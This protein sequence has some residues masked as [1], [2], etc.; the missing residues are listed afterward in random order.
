MV[1][2]HLPTNVGQDS[3]LR[4]GIR[5]TRGAWVVILDADLQ[6]PPEALADLWAM[7]AGQR[8]VFAHRHGRYSSRSR[9][10]TS[11]V[12]RRLIRW[13]AGLPPGAGLYAL[14]DRPTAE[15]IAATSGEPFSLMAV[16]AG[17]R[18]PMVSVP[19]QR[20]PRC[21]GSSAYTSGMRLAKGLRSLIQSFSVRFRSPITMNHSR[22]PGDTLPR[23]SQEPVLDV[24]RRYFRVRRPVRML[25]DRTPYIQRHFDEVAA[26]AGFRAG[27]RVC[28]WGAGLGRF[29]RL[30]AATGVQLD[31]IELSPTQVGDC[32]RALA[33]WPEARV[34][35]GDVATVMRT[36]GG[37]YNAIVGFFMLHHLTGVMGY[38][39][40]AAKHLE[41]GG[42]LVFVEPN[43]WN[44]LYPLQITFTPGMKWQAEKGI[45]ELWPHYLRE[46]CERAGFRSVSI[47]RYGA[48]PRAAYNA[49]DRVGL[50]TLPERLVPPTLKPFQLLLAVL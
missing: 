22:S 6:D 8:V 50:A 18:G 31:A 10:L 40:A 45:Y 36:Q 2:E 41:P 33:D 13:I 46:Q 48:L 42:R 9:R 21:G 25:V 29:S 1:V 28:E 17:T 23:I 19:V 16:F 5:R 34:L 26:A 20:Q 43:P 44:P 30:L 32:R 38:L 37:C 7:R 49:L 35:E 15:T 47:R 12:Y 11:W 4:A 3:A 14:M 27:E 24:Q 39:E